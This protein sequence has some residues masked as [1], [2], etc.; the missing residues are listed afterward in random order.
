MHPDPL[1]HVRRDLPW[2]R[3][4]VLECGRGPHGL[5]FID[6]DVLATMTERHGER[7]T[8]GVCG[9]CLD[10]VRRWPT[11][12]DDPCEA[13]GRDVIGPNADLLARELRA[14]AELVR[15]HPDEFAALLSG[16][17]AVLR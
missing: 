4:V 3:E 15:L 1:Q 16:D 6:R 7:A 17:L 8:R 10:Q 11:F 12:A 14:L 13:A 9:N 5:L 2:R